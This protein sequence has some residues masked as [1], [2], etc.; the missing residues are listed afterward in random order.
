MLICTAKELLSGY[1]EVFI[2]CFQGIFQCR[3][4]SLYLQKETSTWVHGHSVADLLFILREISNPV[5]LRVTAGNIVA[6]YGRLI[7]LRFWSQN[8]LELLQCLLIFTIPE[9]N[10]SEQV[11]QQSSELKQSQCRIRRTISLTCTASAP[12]EDPPLSAS[13]APSSSGNF[14]AAHISKTLAWHDQLHKLNNLRI[15]MSEKIKRDRI[16]VSWCV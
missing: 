7:D 5:K 1:L 6:S 8:W 3:N 10:F 9:V 14:A 12:C 15:P 4:T 11:S 2:T 13:S 16:Y